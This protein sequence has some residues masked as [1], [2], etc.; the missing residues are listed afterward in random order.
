MPFI[1]QSTDHHDQINT[2]DKN[3][4]VEFF[5]KQSGIGNFRL[6]ALEG[7]ASKRHYHRVYSQ[8][9]NYILMDSSQDIKACHAFVT[10]SEY[11]QVNNLRVPH[12]YAQDTQIGL[13]LLEDFGDVTLRQYVQNNPAM[14]EYV[15]RQAVDT[16]IRI[17]Q[18]SDEIPFANYDNHVMFAELDLFL[19]WYVKGLLPVNLFVDAKIELRAIFAQL[20]QRLGSLGRCMVFKD[21]MADNIMVLPHTEANEAKLGILDFQDALYGYVG[22]DLVSLLQDARYTL[23]TDVYNKCLAHFMAHLPESAA[24]KFMQNY[25]LLGTQR[26]LRIIGCFYR[27]AKSLNK[28]KYLDYMP[29]VWLYINSNLEDPGMQEVK[30]WFVKYGLYNGT[31]K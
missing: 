22:Y 20:Y 13:L 28:K 25:I 14:E 6:Q 23:S 24:G 30:R 17:M 26:N 18:T 12:I 7:D 8:N 2:T 10:V 1:K 4:S 3:L 9:K 16:L 27:L 15:Y 29:R 31:N 19:D 11:L 21:Y 5:L